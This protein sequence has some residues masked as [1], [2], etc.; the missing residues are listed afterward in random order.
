MDVVGQVTN[1]GVVGRRSRATVGQA[2]ANHGQKKYISTLD[3][4]GA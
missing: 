2:G 4:F 3:K 1:D